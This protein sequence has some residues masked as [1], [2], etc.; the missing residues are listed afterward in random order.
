MGRSL[1]CPL[2]SPARSFRRSF[3]LMW[4]V[5]LGDL[6]AESSGTLANRT[7]RNF[8]SKVYTDWSTVGTTAPGFASYAMMGFWNDAVVSGGSR[9]SRRWFAANLC[10]VA[11]GSA[12]R[13]GQ[14]MARQRNPTPI[15]TTVDIQNSE[16]SRIWLWCTT[17]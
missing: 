9:I 1:Y 3:C 14:P 13:A 12:T 10:Q 5:S 16:G 2:Q 15:P 11:L 17:E 6:C 8:C 4:F 7:P